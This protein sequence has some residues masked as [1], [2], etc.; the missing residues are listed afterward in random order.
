MG[1][2]DLGRV[3]GNKWYTGT[4]YNNV[5]NPLDGDMFLNVNT[6]IVY[7]Y[8]CKDAIGNWEKI[9]EKI[10]F[11]DVVTL[12]TE[13]EIEGIK[14][15]KGPETF[16]KSTRTD[17]TNTLLYLGSVC[18]PSYESPIKTTGEA[19]QILKT[20]GSTVY[21]GNDVEADLSNYLQK[22][23]YDLKDI[24]RFY[25]EDNESGL[26]VN[27]MTSSIGNYNDN[28][29]IYYESGVFK[30]GSDANDGSGYEIATKKELDNYLLKTGGVIQDSITLGNN[31]LYNTDGSFLQIS[32]D[33]SNTNWGIKHIGQGVNTLYNF[34]TKIDGTV[35]LA[36][37]EDLEN[38]DLSNIHALT[39]AEAT[40]AL[41]DGEGRNIYNTYA[42]KDELANAEL[43]TG[44]TPADEIYLRLDGGN[45]VNRDINFK[46]TSFG[47]RLNNSQQAIGFND[48]GEPTFVNSLGRY[49]CL[50]T[51]DLDGNYIYYYLPE[52]KDSFNIATKEELEDGTIIPKKSDYADYTNHITTD[53]YIEFK[54]EQGTHQGLQLGEYFE[55]DGRDLTGK[56]LKAKEADSAKNLEVQTISATDAAVDSIY[57]STKGLYSVTLEAYTEAGYATGTCFNIMLSIIDLTKNIKTTF[58][59]YHENDYAEYCSLNYVSTEEELEMGEIT[60]GSYYCDPSKGKTYG[61]FKIIDCKK[62]ISY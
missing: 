4:D 48:V 49:F 59:P 50:A 31:T 28:A 53:A 47:L 24:V 16:L 7:Q 21:W 5:T 22:N 37:L 46:N 30:Y 39:A 14:T 11:P 43:G 61:S 57:I 26:S 36:S 17:A 34:P 20:N 8:Q 2:I 54:D 45:Q 9:T 29:R 35:T 3:V 27:P 52:G 56:V 19:G 23:N 32:N 6:A 42:T 58:I 55:V 25:N 12:T 44:S 10:N 13:Q 15:F 38:I 60:I 33:S 41:Q 18:I 51:D 1:R 40:K 62:I